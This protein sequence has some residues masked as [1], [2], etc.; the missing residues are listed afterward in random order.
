MGM[1]IHT[2]IVDENGKIKY[3]DLYEGRNSEWFADLTERAEHNMAYANWNPDYGLSKNFDPNTDPKYINCKIDED[4]RKWCFDFRNIKVGDFIK[5]YKKSKPY[6][7]AG[8]CTKYEAWLYHNK[9]VVPD[10]LAKELSEYDIVADREFIEVN[11]P[12]D[13]A[14]VIY[15]FIM[16]HED[17]EDDDYFNYFFDN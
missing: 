9:G 8:W 11:N 6:I 12:Y 16:E 14:T 17:I 5:W 3:T 13:P 1:D 4:I 2:Y 15:N 10:Y 7:E